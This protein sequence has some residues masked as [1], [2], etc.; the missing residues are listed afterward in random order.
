[1]KSMGLL[2][3]IILPPFLN[4]KLY[5]LRILPS[6]AVRMLAH[7]IRKRRT[8]LPIPRPAFR[9]IMIYKVPGG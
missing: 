5:P 2:L 7:C 6:I 1:M 3:C 8:M 4:E 9:F